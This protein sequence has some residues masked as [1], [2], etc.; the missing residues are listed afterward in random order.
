LLTAPRCRPTKNHRNSANLSVRGTLIAQYASVL[1]FQVGDKLSEQS[2]SS[3]RAAVK[4][5]LALCYRKGNT[6]LGVLAECTAKLR[7]EGWSEPDI[8]TVESAVRKVLAG[9]VSYEDD[10]PQE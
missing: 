6:P 9:V 10:S 4:D 5:C 8:R 2:E 7:L 1:S 3:I